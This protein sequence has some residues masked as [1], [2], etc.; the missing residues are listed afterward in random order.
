V[1]TTWCLR[2]PTS[3]YTYGVPAVPEICPHNLMCCAAINDM[4]TNH[5]K[6]NAELANLPRKL[7]IALSPSRDD[8]PHTHINDVGLVA[9]KHPDT[10]EVLISVY[11]ID[12]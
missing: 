4:Y 11:P 2:E 1:L 10:G 9:V 7:N 3:Q 6:G 12:F 5:G 8:F